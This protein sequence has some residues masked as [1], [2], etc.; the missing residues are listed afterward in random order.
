M[1]LLK[2]FPEIDR[3]FAGS[4][5]I[6]AD[7]NVFLLEIDKNYADKDLRKAALNLINLELA[8]FQI[9]KDHIDLKPLSKEIRL[10]ENKIQSKQPDEIQELKKLTI[11]MIAEKLRWRVERLLT[12]LSQNGLNRTGEQS[13]RG[14]EFNDVKEMLI[15]RLKALQ[16]MDKKEQLEQRKTIKGKKIKK[17]LNARND[18]YSKIE[19]IGLGKVIYIRK[20]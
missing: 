11:E 16:R 3:F 18:V 13:L 10:K 5:F 14:N 15:S 9:V 17:S 12:V 2:S 7:L 8:K 4:K 6:D 1:N 20:S 19:E